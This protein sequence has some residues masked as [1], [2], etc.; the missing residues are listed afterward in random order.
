MDILAVTANA[1]MNPVH[2]V[3]CGHI[4]LIVFGIYLGKE[5][6]GHMVILCWIIWDTAQLFPG[7]SAPFY[8]PTSSVWGFQF[9][10]SNTNCYLILTILVGMK[11]YLIAVLNFISLMTS[12]MKHLLM[13]LL[14]VCIPSLEMS[15]QILSLVLIVWFV[16][17]LLNCKYSL[18][19]LGSSLLS[20]IWLSEI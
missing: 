16:F 5:L 11:E 4:F 3:M 14:A 6:W 17:L 12:G 15:V 19:I 7:A 9:L 18:Y 8:I 2:R 20:D 13:H 10:I 1:I